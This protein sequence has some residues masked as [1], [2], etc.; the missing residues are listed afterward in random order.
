VFTGLGGLPV[1]GPGW[2]AAVPQSRH[3]GVQ[4]A[5]IGLELVCPLVVAFGVRGA[6]IEDQ[7]PGGDLL[8]VL[9][10]QSGAGGVQS[11]GLVGELPG[12]F[13]FPRPVRLA[14]GDGRAVGFRAAAVIQVSGW[15][16][17]VPA[18]RGDVM[19]IRWVRL[20]GGVRFWPGR[21]GSGLELAAAAG[22]AVRLGLGCRSA[23]G[24]LPGHSVESAVDVA[25]SF[26]GCGE[27]G[28]VREGLTDAAARM[29]DLT[30]CVLDAGQCGGLACF[31]LGK[32]VF[33]SHDQAGGVR[34]AEA[35]SRQLD[36][37]ARCSFQPDAHVRCPK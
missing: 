34:A 33:Q 27:F 36:R 29:G 4:L 3:T 11:G 26:A 10:P 13:Q 25:D 16:G 6:G 18:L 5:G 15:P 14:S 19:T 30:A 2:E 23:T 32:P 35:G 8:P 9:G 24:I 21:L 7:L 1:S 20:A 22:T 31:E 12:C 37:G 28:G 17:V